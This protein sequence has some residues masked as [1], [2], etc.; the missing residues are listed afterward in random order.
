MKKVPQAEIDAVCEMY[1]AGL[2]YGRIAQKLKIGMAGV[3]HR[4]RL[5]GVPRTR[6]EKRLKRID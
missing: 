5:G 2:S 1:R 4:L 6:K 3:D